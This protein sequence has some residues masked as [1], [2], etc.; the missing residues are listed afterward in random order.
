ME[1][2]LGGTAFFDALKF[3]L[4]GVFIFIGGHNARE[5]QR[6]GCG[7]NRKKSIPLKRK[8]ILPTS[9]LKLWV[10]AV[11]LLLLCAI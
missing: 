10:K 2:N 9:W 3:L 6:I 1:T 8:R 5:N 11:R 4:W 7:N